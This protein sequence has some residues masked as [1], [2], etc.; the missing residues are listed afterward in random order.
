MDF[1]E[2][3]EKMF[4]KAVGEIGQELHRLGVQGAAE[5]GSSIFTGNAYVPYGQGQNRPGSVH[6][7]EGLHNDGKEEIQRENEGRSM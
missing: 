5:I 1:G 6:G 4:G 7:M 3:L 2:K